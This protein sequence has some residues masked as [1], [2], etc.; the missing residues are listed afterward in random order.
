MSSHKRL[1]ILVGGVGAL[2]L[3]ALA[4]SSYWPHINNDTEDASVYAHWDQQPGDLAPGIDLADNVRNYGLDHD[5]PYRFKTNSLGFRSPEPLPSASPTIVI[6]GD[7]FAFGMG[8]D[9]GQTFSDSLQSALRKKLPSAVVHNAAV[10]G[11]SILDQLE[12]WQD[13]LHK[14]NA[15]LVILCHTASDLKEMARPTSFRRW[16]RHEEDVAAHFDSE[17][18]QIMEA[19]IANSMEARAPW[20]FTQDELQKRLGP[21]FQQ[22]LVSYLAQYGELVVELN[23]AVKRS[24]SKARLVVVEWVT[25]YGMGSLNVSSLNKRLNE[26]PIP[27]FNGDSALS[28]QHKYSPNELYLPDKHFSAIGNQLA[29]E[30]CATWLFAQQILNPQ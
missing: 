5:L 6:L 20:I 9:N 24:H 15:D 8:V 16:A 14:L 22:S 2:L 28:K 23:E 1:L 19:S 17:V 4:V 3:L 12:Q 10:P 13:E 18:Q 25:G 27:V 21:R 11:Y 26:V 7:S 29:G 30:Q